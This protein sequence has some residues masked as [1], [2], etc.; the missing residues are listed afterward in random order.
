MK[1]LFK[2]KKNSVYLKENGNVLKMGNIGINEVKIQNKAYELGIAP[3]IFSSGPGYIEMEFIKGL[4]I[5][6]Y[7]KKININRESIMAKVSNAENLLYN[8]G[9]DHRDFTGENIMITDDEKVIIID[10]GS[11][12]ISNVPIPQKQRRYYK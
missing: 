7:L 4:V 12:I 11:S 10:Y 3:K 8:N 6:E 2:N 5:E 1:L 9:I